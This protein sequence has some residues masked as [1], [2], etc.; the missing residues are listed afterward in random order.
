MKSV[1]VH[2][3]SN[4]Q[5]VHSPPDSSA[6]CKGMGRRQLL[7]AG[8]LSA[9]GLMA[10]WS[11]QAAPDAK[12]ERIRFGLCADV[13][14]DVIHDPDER[15]RTFVDAMSTEHVDFIMQLG[16]FCQP[17]P[18]NQGFLDIWNQFQ[19]PHYHVLG[20]HDMDDGA[21]REDTLAC[22]GMAAKHY[23]FDRGGYHFV[24][25]DG[26]DKNENPAPGY[27]RYIGKPQLAWLERDLEA[28]SA[29]TFVFSHQ[30]L[31]HATGVENTKEVQAL[32]ESINH[33]AGYRK[34]AA[35]FSG[36]HHLDFRTTING[37]DYI[38]VNSMSYYWVGGNYIRTRFAEEVETA[39]PWVR[40]T[41]PYRDPLYALVTLEPDGA[42]TITGRRSSFIPPTPDD[43]GIPDPKG[44]I[45]I[46]A[47]I[48]DRR[49]R[50]R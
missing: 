3:P 18:K 21:S 35:C 45:D 34:V 30:S 28:T 36:H 1:S 38:Q 17:I 14:K 9:G 12:R 20:N 48:S 50:Y 7:R 25:L 22:W 37:I 44:P 29:P 5:S 41:A 47:V 49:L 33:R 23:S 26:N 10:P 46:T 24:V 39:H 4:H 16:D 8:L 42:M 32:L 31:E 19:G 13:H 40:H 15:L 43:M 2:Q 11:A 27:A 6:R